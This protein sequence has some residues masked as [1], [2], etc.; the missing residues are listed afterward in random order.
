MKKWAQFLMC[1]LFSAGI[2]LIRNLSQNYVNIVSIPV[3]A[4]S[5]IDGR[6]RASTTDATVT[7]QVNASGFRHLSLGR[8]PR[9]PV[10]VAFSQSDFQWAGG[11][12]YSI[13]NS[14]LF[15]YTSAIFGDGVSI[16]SFISESPRFSFPEV[17]YKR[18]PVR[19]VHSIGF[20]PQ[21]MAYT[22][23]VIQPDSVIV[24]GESAKLENIDH[25]LTKPLELT[26]LQASVHGKVKLEVPSGM[27]LSTQEVI[28]SMEVAR[29]VEI[30]SEVKI[31][32][33][34]VPANMEMIV[35]PSNATVSFRCLF[36]A[37][38][39]PAAS[40]VFYVDYRDFA[41]SLSGKCLAVPDNLP[42]GVIDYTV[43]PEVF[44]CIVRSIEQK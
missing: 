21:Y 26:D 2:W 25:V 27:R 7:A 37:N 33:K 12:V 29:Y 16:E 35:L 4:E 42:S 9:R 40:T 15:K 17:S 6:A 28:Y 39:N 41:S 14:S 34:N 1:L 10:R 11:D 20:R 23:M 32:A 19:K 30:R 36:P 18:V 22:P 3:V 38:E 13:P 5:N 8:G 44:D 24:Y 31:E 43:T